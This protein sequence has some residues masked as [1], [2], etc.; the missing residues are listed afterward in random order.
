MEGRRRSVIG[1]GGELFSTLPRE[2]QTLLT[3]DLLKEARAVTCPV[4]LLLGEN[5]PSW[6]RDITQ[7]LSRTIGHA[8]VAVLPGQGH[9]AIDS[10]PDLVV[11]SLV[12]FLGDLATEA[13]EHSS[14]TGR[15]RRSV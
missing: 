5:S 10:A 3:I 14:S 13:A 9:E 8:D 6:A 11:G 1:A 7:A 12:R 15:Y 2:A 4:L